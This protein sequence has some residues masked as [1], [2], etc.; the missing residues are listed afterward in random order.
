MGLFRKDRVDELVGAIEDKIDHGIGARGP[1]AH[2]YNPGQAADRLSALERDSSREEI[3]AAGARL[4][5]ED[6][7][8]H[9]TER[10]RVSRQ[11]RGK[12]K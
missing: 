5:R 4:N 11:G 12:G 7:E 2:L 10:D 1:W 8:R 3:D 6:I 9:V